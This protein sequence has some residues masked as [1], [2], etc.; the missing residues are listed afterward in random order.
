M[1]QRSFFQ[2]DLLW[3]NAVRAMVIDIPMDARCGGE[4]S[5][6]GLQVLFS[7]LSFDGA[8]APR[9]ALHLDR[10]IGAGEPRPQRSIEEKALQP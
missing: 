9:Q 7:C 8:S 4:V 3:L 1:S 5:V 2:T 10:S 6:S